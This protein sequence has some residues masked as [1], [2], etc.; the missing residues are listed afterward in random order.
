MAKPFS[1][2]IQTIDNTKMR[3]P[4]YS[5]ID[6]SKNP[7]RTEDTTLVNT[8][9]DNTSIRLKGNTANIAASHNSNQKLTEN[10]NIT[11]S[12]EEKHLTNRFSLDTDDIVINGHKLNPAL[13]E[14]TDFRQY[15]DMYQGSHAVGGFTMF[16]TVMTVTWDHQLR[17]YVLV[18][19]LARMP[20]FSPKTNVPEILETLGIQDPTKIMNNYT[21]KQST[22]DVKT[23]YEQV[24]KEHGDNKK[25]ADDPSGGY[26]GSGTST[27]A[28]K[29]GAS[30]TVPPNGYAA[31]VIDEARRHIGVPY[32]FGGKDDS[33][34]DCSGHTYVAYSAAGLD[35][36]RMADEQYE[37]FKDKHALVNIEQAQPGDMI[38]FQYTYEDETVNNNGITHVGIVSSGNTVDTMQVVHAGSS[39]G[40]AE[41]ALNQWLSDYLPPG[42]CVGSISLAFGGK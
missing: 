35:V 30:G 2:E 23:W 28:P 21:V 13:Y 12:L 37:F 7:K 1:F 10:Q 34:Y 39:T 29:S 8:D 24:K 9:G 33:G 26:T 14:Y 25:Y 31:A 6:K 5:L 22:T 42:A 18:R 41:V 27:S 32:V 15:K 19:R 40:V 36:P 4:L 3:A 38:F 20:M 17:K 16:G 11:T